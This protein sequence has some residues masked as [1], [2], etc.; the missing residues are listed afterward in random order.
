MR[1][2]VRL[3]FLFLFLILTS[4]LSA[5][6]GQPPDSLV[7]NNPS[8]LPRFTETVAVRDL[9]IPPKAAKELRRSQNALRSGDTRSSAQHLE[10]ALKIYPNYL[11]G[12]NSLGARY[13]ELHEY[14]KAAAEFQKAIDIDP[15]VMQPVNN[16]SVALFLEQR[17]VDAEAAARRALDLDPH[18]STAR[19]MLGAILATEDRN[20]AEAMEMLRQTKNQFPDSRLLL[21][22]ILERRCEMKE[23]E[24]ELRD[25]L[26]APDAEKRQN[27]ER[28]L[29]RLTQ[30]STANATTEPKTP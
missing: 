25:Y 19:Y 10:R 27:A 18:D 8:Q 16:L 22:Q 9:L 24:K 12:H 6:T 7:P 29:A 30:K 20:P 4:R 14:E 26:A 23:A 17:Y 1:A 2:S 13:I 21:A 3:V 15:R 11:E 28:W 5:Q